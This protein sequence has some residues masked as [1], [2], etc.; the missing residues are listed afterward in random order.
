[1]SSLTH[2]PKVLVALD[3]DRLDKALDLAQQLNPSDCRVKVGKELFTLYGPKAVEQL[4][5]LGFDVFLDLKFHDIPATVAKAVAAAAQLGVWMVNVH[6][7]GGL[8]MLAAAREALTPFSQRPLLIGVTVLTSM[9]QSE[10]FQTGINRP[11]A[12]QVLSLAGLT[13]EA[14]LDGV[15]C[16]AEETRVLNATFGDEFV[17]VTPGIRPLGSGADDQRRIVTPE[18]ALRAGSHYLVIGRPI[19][20]SPDPAKACQDIVLSITQAK[21]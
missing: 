2:G 20:L 12:E 18:A 4:Q 14:G 11:V 16:S 1:M 9:D 10:L 6:A 7:S 8:R 21:M 5:K 13:E 17:L 19:T 3:F 15:V